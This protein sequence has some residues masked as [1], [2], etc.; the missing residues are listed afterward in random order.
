MME[1]TQKDEQTTGQIESR[2]FTITK[3][4]SMSSYYDSEYYDSE[5]DYEEHKGSA[6]ETSSQEMIYEM[7][8]KFFTAIEQST[9]C[10]MIMSR[11]ISE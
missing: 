7:R 3:E 11:Q 2:F 4:A 1:T 9:F 10:P 5:D 8:Q 6:P